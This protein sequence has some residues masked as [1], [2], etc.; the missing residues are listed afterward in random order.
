[1][2]QDLAGESANRRLVSNDQHGTFDMPVVINNYIGPSCIFHDPIHSGKQDAEDGA[3]PWLA[4]NLQSAVVPPNDSVDRGETEPPSGEFCCEEWVEDLG[5]RTL[6][7]AA[8]GV[9]HF[10]EHIK[11]AR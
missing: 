4:L 2:L 9:N 7:H 3:T 5:K 11:A 10:D 8:A 6:I 1:M